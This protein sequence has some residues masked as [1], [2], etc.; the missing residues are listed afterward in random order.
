M[1]EK[2]FVRNTI[3]L[4]ICLSL[5]SC[6]SPQNGGASNPLK[7]AFASDDPC[8]NNARNWGLVIGSVAG[9]A[10]GYFLGDKKTGVVIGAGLAG[11]ALGGLIGADMDKK[12]CE[13]S[14]IAKQ[15]DLQLNMATVN[16]N[17]EVIENGGN[18]T[19]DQSMGLTVTLGEK[20]GIG[21]FETNSDQLTPKAQQYF[22][23]IADT[24]N[25]KL[26]AKQITNEKE[27]AAYLATAAQKK[28][29]LIGHTDD[30]GDTEYNAN[31]SERRA[32][33]V[34]KFLKEHGIDEATL[35]FQ[36][37]GETLPQADNRTE[38]GRAQNRRVELVEITGEANFQKYLEAR[39]P[40][41]EYYRPVD[42]QAVNSADRKK[43]PTN[44]ASTKTGS[45]MKSKPDVVADS[46][47]SSPQASTPTVAGSSKPATN[48]ANK[49]TTPANANTKG[50]N[51]GG[52]PLSL[53]NAQVDAGT[54][55][56]EEAGFSLISKAYANDAVV[57]ASCIKDRPRSVGAVKSLKDGKAYATS[58]YLKGLYD[59]S[60]H[61]TLNGNLLMLN[62]VAVLNDSA[63]PAKLPEFKIYADYDPQ[64]SKTAK[65]DITAKP[66]VNT[67]RGSKGVLYRVFTQ[68][69]GGIQ[70]M[71]VLFPSQGGMAAKTGKVIYQQQGEFYVAEY[72]PKMIQR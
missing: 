2:P 35:Y 72:R 8:S 62:H 28:L 59:T 69:T 46:A 53:A 41:H 40:K 23:A 37:A 70:C 58:D 20:N 31:L 65:P 6:A 25:P 47:Q 38:A 45:K 60:W 24:Y 57:L 21:H 30:V 54:L 32:K 26:V 34:A 61:D 71:D 64:K 12:R 67:Y 29:L 4:A 56:Q 3:S 44:L 52:Q 55:I 36:G 22:A 27:K 68:G 5:I 48:T 39:K 66:N 11:L 14:K 17:G 18:D 19:K 49:T 16:A 15:Y 33:A 51:F 42:T 9:A 13:L 10:A 43:A 7:E 63:A 50:I 1:L